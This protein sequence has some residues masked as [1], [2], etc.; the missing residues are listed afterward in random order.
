MKSRLMIGLCAAA[1]VCASGVGIFAQEKGAGPRRDR[2]HTG[3]VSEKAADAVTNVVA[4]LTSKGRTGTERKY[5]LLATEQATIDKIKVLVGKDATVKGPVAMEGA[6]IEVTDIV[7]AVKGGR[8]DTPK[9]ATPA[10]VAPA[11]QPPAGGAAQAPA[12]Q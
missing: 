9:E 6:A 5:N 11:A 7:E 12:A 10:P 3:L 4:V 1:V 2:P 8:A